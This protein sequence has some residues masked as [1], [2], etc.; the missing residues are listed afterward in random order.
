MTQR[1]APVSD[2]ADA[3]AKPLGD[4][5]DFIRQEH[6]R[7]LR[8]CADLDDL[9]NALELEPV[10]ERV[11]SLQS[12]L[13]EDLPRHIQDEEAD[14]FPA[15]TR[16]TGDDADTAVILDQL[17]AEHE[18]DMGLVDPILKEFEAIIRD[19][20][21]GDPPRFFMNARMFAE[22]QRRHLIWENRVVLPLA[23]RV[24]TEAD[25]RALTESLAR[26]RVSPAPRART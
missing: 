8:V 14:L 2:A 4:P 10:V 15:L 24:L 22:T 6:D 3:L 26:R 19:G 21:P 9:F 5:I 18:L 17:I 11:L 12:F 13:T 23:D 20:V 16:R 1:D 7:Q 25:K